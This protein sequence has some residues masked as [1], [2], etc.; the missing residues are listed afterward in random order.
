MLDRSVAELRRLGMTEY[1]ARAYVGLVGLGEGTARQ[2]HEACGVPRPRIYDI[3]ES[4]ET[5]GFVEVWTG[6]PKYYRAIPPD[7]LIRVLRNE[8]ETSMHIASTELQDL[9]L[10]GRK[11]TFPV[12]HIKGD[13]SIREQI[14]EMT[15]EVER[16]LI[17]ICTKTSLF[18]PMVKDLKTIAE[19][20]D[21]KCMVPEGAAAFSQALGGAKVMEPHLGKDPMATIYAKIFSGKLRTSDELYRAEMLIIVDGMRSLLVY[22]VN[23]ER[24]AI[25]FELPI[26][27]VLQR[28]AITML[29]EGTE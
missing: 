6:K 18:R 24:T 2:V 8:L 5:K 20:A 26:L 17:V 23:G 16:E 14:R 9:S 29:M 21:L 12:W 22:E 19:R 3:L 7:R 28:T 15:G 25:V 4:L 11:R 13:L 1:E 10:E 27:T